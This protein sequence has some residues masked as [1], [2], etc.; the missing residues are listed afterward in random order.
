MSTWCF[1]VRFQVPLSWAWFHVSCVVSSDGAFKFMACSIGSSLVR[2]GMFLWGFFCNGETS[3][4]YFGCYW[5]LSGE[6]VC[7]EMCRSSSCCV[8]WRVDLFLFFGLVVK[9]SYVCGLSLLEALPRFVWLSPRKHPV[10]LMVMVSISS[11]LSFELS[12]LWVFESRS[13]PWFVCLCAP[14]WA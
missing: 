5:L 9:L 14:L 4:G 10:V 13:L 11:V 1:R 7:F 6:K 8:V 2:N 12:V 3:R